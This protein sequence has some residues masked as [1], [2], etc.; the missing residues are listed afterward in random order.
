[1]DMEISKS[2]PGFDCLHCTS[3]QYSWKWYET[4]YSSSSYGLGQ[5]GLYIWMH[6]MDSNKTAGEEVRW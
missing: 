4:N 2:N 3:H 5:T 1:M 6:Y